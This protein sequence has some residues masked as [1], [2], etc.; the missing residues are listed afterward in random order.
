V[1]ETQ[2]FSGVQPCGHCGNRAPMPI[3][4][5]YAEHTGREEQGVEWNESTHYELLKCPACSGIVLRTFF[6]HDGYMDDAEGPTYK[7]LYPSERPKP[8]GLPKTVATD[9]EAAQRVKNLSPNAYGVLLGRVLELVCEDR[10]AKGRSL[11]EKLKDLASKNEI[12]TKLVDVAQSLKDLRNVG[13]HAALGDLT[14]GEVPILEDLTRAILEYV[15]SAPALAEAAVKSLDALK[16]RR[17]K[18]ERPTPE[19]PAP[20]NGT[21]APDAQ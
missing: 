6:W 4:R 5:E 8:R 3:V 13:A 15:Y 12:P 9:Y 21:P 19:N 20:E 10:S 2:K 7:V 16:R 11:H 1:A 14:P 18:P 17:P